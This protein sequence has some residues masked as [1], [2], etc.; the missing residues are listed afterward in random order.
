MAGWVSER[1]RDKSAERTGGFALCAHGRC[2]SDPSWAPGTHDQR[3]AK[4][5]AIYDVLIALRGDEVTP[6]GKVAV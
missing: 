5:N 4:M 1:D 2:R 3:D 6:S